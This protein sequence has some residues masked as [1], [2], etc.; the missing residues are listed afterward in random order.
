MTQLV[1]SW[2]DRIPVL[3]TVAAFSTDITGR[4]HPQDYDHQESMLAPITKS[5]WM[6][7]STASIADVTRRAIKFGTTLPVGPVFLS[8]PDDLLRATG[9]ADIYDGQLFNVAMKI[10]PDQH[11]VEAI[12]K[13]LIEA[14]NP[15][16]TAGDEI[17]LCQAEAEVVELAN[18]L[19]IPVSTIA[20]S[21]GNWSR[22]YPTR[23]VQFVG[24]FLPGGHFPGPVDVHFNVGSQLGERRMPNAITISMRSDPTGL[25]RSWPI[26]MSIIANIKL[27]LA[28]I[29]AAIKSMATA[30]RLKLIA[31]GRSVRTRDYTASMA[32]MHAEIVRNLGNG[33]SITMERL[34]I[35][36]ENGL[37]K[38]AIFVTDCESG[39]IMDSMMTFGGTDKTLVSTSANIL[40]WAQAAATGV[41]LARPNRPVVSAMGDGSAMFGGPQPLWSQ[42]RYNAPITNIVVNNRSYNNERNRIWSFSGPQ[43]FR[44]GKDM[45]SYNGSPDVDFAKAAAAYGVEGET[46]SDPAKIQEQ[47]GRAKRANIEGRPYLLDILVDRAGVG[48][49]S[50]WY[51]PYSIA[52]KRTRKV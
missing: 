37:D 19:G 35:E 24:T 26:E 21:V 11:D 6:A 33:S 40:G 17:T 5:F 47:L 2:K 48:A 44:S 29:I 18:L 34:G 41:K 51:P 42:A 9:T 31:D 30:D 14:R 36:L 43:Q 16:V 52:A 15:L 20:S 1:N 50:E 13:L 25:A 3:L 10:R 28:D 4:D 12:A 22:P 7:E 39:R 8:I 49:A 27:G 23:D 38:E 45:T 32:K 46:V